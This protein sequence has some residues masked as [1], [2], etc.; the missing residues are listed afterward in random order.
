MLNPKYR[1]ER[2]IILFHSS[3][4]RWKGLV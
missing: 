3:N 1:I 4:S 2:F